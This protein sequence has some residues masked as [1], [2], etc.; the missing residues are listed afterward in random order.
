M[1]KTLK[2]KGFTIMELVATLAILTI[3][4]VIAIPSFISVYRKFSKNYY[5]SLE[6][7]I[8]MSANDY[9]TDNK[10][11]IPRYIGETSNVDGRELATLGYLEKTLAGRSSSEMCSGYARVYKSAKGKY[12]YHG[13]IECEQNGVVTYSS[14][15]ENSFCDD[16]YGLDENQFLV[17]PNNGVISMPDNYN[18]YKDASGNYYSDVLFV[19]GASTY[20]K[21]IDED[22]MVYT[23]LSNTINPSSFY[24]IENGTLKVKDPIN[25]NSNDVNVIRR[26]ILQ[27]L[28]VIYGV[29][30]DQQSYKK[31]VNELIKNK[32]RIKYNYEGNIQLSRIKEDGTTEVVSRAL[33]ASKQDGIRR[34]AGETPNLQLVLKRGSVVIDDNDK[35]GGSLGNVDLSNIGWTNQVIS[36]SV[37]NTISNLNSR[38]S[39][40]FCS[41]DGGNNYEE[42]DTT[43][44][45]SGNGN[46]TYT[47]ENTL[48]NVKIVGQSIGGVISEAKDFSVKVDRISPSGNI[49]ISS[50]NAS[51]NSK[52]VVL[53]YSLND[54]ASGLASAKLGS[55]E[56][57][58]GS[59]GS[60]TWESDNHSYSFGGDYDGGNRNVYLTVT[61]VAGNQGS[62]TNAAAYKIYKAC[63]SGNVEKYGNWSNSG[64]CSDNCGGKQ[65]Q[66]KSTRDKNSATACAPATKKV[67]C[68]GKE[69]DGNPIWNSED[70]HCDK[71]N[72]YTKYGI[73]KYKSTV[74]G[75]ACKSKNVTREASCSNS[76]ASCV[77]LEVEGD[78]TASSG[79]HIV[80]RL[81]VVCDR[82]VKALKVVYTYNTSSSDCKTTTTEYSGWGTGSGANNSADFNFRGCGGSYSLEY[83]ASVTTLNG[84]KHNIE[85]SSANFSEGK[86][87]GACSPGAGG[88]W[89]MYG[90]F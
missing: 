9:F 37:R 50:T 33:K 64:S 7:S 39:Q 57:F 20:K 55:T 8:K 79:N 86:S 88:H 16:Q 89:N 56:V 5:K 32:V 3:I 76:S 74:D 14:K 87:G 54:S 68:G 18:K 70:S 75:T 1:L 22:K 60:S 61:D 80:G 81:R 52:D 42:C 31:Y 49:F 17:P 58:D 15:N 72:N 66:V 6:G 63:E 78:C 43:V 85:S 48:A 84:S 36:L 29:P 53:S 40:Y 73:Q 59:V 35:V 24:I 41:Y 77:V 82:P 4:L 45:I 13:C 10:K 38:V 83:T 47:Y 69:T 28:E 67:D 65:I 30:T 34:R 90:Q 2:K 27:R 26:K 62:V 12:K 23:N 21:G 19:V 11:M 51:W 44:S 25:F 71:N 46:A